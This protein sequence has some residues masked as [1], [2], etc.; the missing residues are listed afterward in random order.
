[1]TYL[2]ASECADLINE[3]LEMLDCE[4]LKGTIF[5]SFN[6]RFTRRAGDANYNKRRIRLSTKIFRE[7]TVE[8]RKQTVIHETCHIAV[9]H[10]C[11]LSAA[12]HGW[13]WKKCMRAMGQPPE[14]CHDIEVRTNREVAQCNCPDGCSV[15]PTVAKRIRAGKRYRCRKCGGTLSFSRKLQGTLL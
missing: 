6:S 9:R 2:T 12:S 14:R 10:I 1:M 3:T 11:G 13:E 8:R 15:G 4:E 5:V 7:M